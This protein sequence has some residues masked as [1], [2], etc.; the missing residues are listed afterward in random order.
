MMNQLSE[1]YGLTPRAIRFYEEAGLIET[2]RDRLNRR[3]F[4]ARARERLHLIARLR[5]AGLGISAIREVLALEVEGARA[6]LHEAAAKLRELRVDLEQRVSEVDG[7][8]LDF[9][10]R[11]FPSRTDL[12]RP[13]AS[14]NL[15]AISAMNFHPNGRPSELPPAHPGQRER[16]G[17]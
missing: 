7:A 6:Q 16:T 17:S 2:T 11:P 12:A 10:D 9:E 15:R 13:P 3:R 8:L 5:R 4:D 14:A 1:L